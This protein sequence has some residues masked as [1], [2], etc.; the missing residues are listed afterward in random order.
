MIYLII[1]NRPEFLDF[2][3]AQ[4]QKCKNVYPV[5]L[6]NGPRFKNHA[7]TSKA[8]YFYQENWRHNSDAFNWFRSN[9]QKDDHL[10]LMDDDIYLSGD[11]VAEC[12]TWLEAGFDRVVYTRSYLFDLE[13]GETATTNWFARSVG[14]AWAISKDLWR[15]KPWPDRPVDAM[16][17]YF[18]DLPEHNVKMIPQAKITHLLHGKNVILERSIRQ[19]FDTENDLKLYSE[20]LKFNL[21]FKKGGTDDQ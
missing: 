21:T 13:A 14:G 2:S 12:L 10:F 8:I 5:V 4:A 7:G 11:S 18:I 20:I 6:A 3:I 17:R 16:L 1:T 9:Y 15:Q 19:R